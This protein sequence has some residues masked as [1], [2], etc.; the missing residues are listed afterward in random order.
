M[1]NSVDPDQLASSILFANEGYIQTRVKMQFSFQIFKAARQLSHI[2][3]V[4]VKM[5]QCLGYITD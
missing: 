4:P 5:P 2:E 1:A 3:A